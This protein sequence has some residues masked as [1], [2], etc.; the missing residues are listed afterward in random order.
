[1]VN[2]TEKDLKTLIITVPSSGNSPSGYEKVDE[3]SHVEIRRQ[4]EER[5]RA[6]REEED[7]RREEKRIQDEMKR[8]QDEKREK[9]EREKRL[10][11]SDSPVGAGQDDPDGAGKAE[12]KEGE[13]S[14]VRNKTGCQ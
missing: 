10:M 9:E 12:R 7:R 11:D 3:P 2:K 1:M 13:A 6:R 14:K 8:A 4:E 5:E